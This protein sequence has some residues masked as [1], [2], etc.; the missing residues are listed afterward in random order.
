MVILVFTRVF[1][2]DQIT[3]H[4]GNV[5]YTQNNPTKTNF[6]CVCFS[7]FSNYSNNFQTSISCSDGP[8]FQP[9]PLPS[10]SIHIFHTFTPQRKIAGENIF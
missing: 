5:I 6:V 2:M 9:S 1:M 4:T 8:G 7:H 3:N 10:T